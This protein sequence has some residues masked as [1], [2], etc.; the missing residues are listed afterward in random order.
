[1]NARFSRFVGADGIGPTEG[2][3][4]IAKKELDFLETKLGEFIEDDDEVRFV[5]ALRSGSYAKNTLLRR[6][7]AGDFDADIAIY[8]EPKNGDEESLPLL[9][10]YLERLLR[11]AYKD[12]TARPPTF[13]RTAKSAVRVKFLDSPKINID[14]VP[15]ISRPH[16]TIPNWGAI[17]RR[18]GELRD[19]SVTEHITFV[20]DRNK[21]SKAVNFNHMVMV[22][23][24]W[25]NHAFDEDARG[26]LCSFALELIVGKA[27]DGTKDRLN[28]DW[29]HDLLEIFTWLI[30]HRFGAPISFPDSR[31]PKAAAPVDGVVKVIDPMNAG[32][33]VSHDWTKAAADEVLFQ[34]QRFCDVL[35]DAMNELNAE[36]EEEALT[37]LD[38]ILPRF[39]EFSEEQ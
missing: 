33:N 36:Q 10:D 31:V 13:D 1:M 34:A 9:L 5:K 11:R 32:N 14:A 38:S 26:Q 17:P 22:A 20:S 19:T 28:G 18:D 39:S 23:K 4:K 8:V 21:V 35:G 29:G 37:L 27:F 30:R 25:R 7:E 15:V 12:R 16:D 24:W 3:L 6:H 2:Q